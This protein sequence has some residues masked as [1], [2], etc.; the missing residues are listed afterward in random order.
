MPSAEDFEAAGL[1]DPVLDTDSGRLELL[2]WLLGGGFT[3]EEMRRAHGTPSVGL[4]AMAT[5]R[6]LRAGPLG[7]RIEALESSGL[8][9]GDFDEAVKAVGLVAVDGAP[10]QEVG[11][12]DADAA[13]IAALGVLMSMFSRD[14]AMATLRVIG[15]SVARIAEASVSLFLQDVESPHVK[16]GG[17]ELV[18]AQLAYEAVGLLDANLGTHLGSLLR[19][20]TIQAIE[21]TRRAT[22][23]ADERFDYRFAVGFVDLVGFTTLSADMSPQELGV[24]IR[25]FQGRAHELVAAAGAQVVKLIGDEVM[26]VS[27]SADAACLAAHALLSGFESFDRQVVPRGG[28]A[29]GNVLLRGGD[30]YGSV[31]NLAARLVDEAVPQELLVA[32]E[33]AQAASGCEFAPAGRRMVKGFSDPVVVRS[34]LNG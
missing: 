3:I 1:Y 29:Y 4:V 18:Q 17:S 13:T 5:D 16:A 34:F 9:P 11:F 6:R 27:P 10:H 8:S 30:Y 20:H 12:T 31:V 32:D 7:T 15:S 23:G 24:F 21:R 25:D 28:L 14:E 22:V 19:R 26:L 2:E 33:V